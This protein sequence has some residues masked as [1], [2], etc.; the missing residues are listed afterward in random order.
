MGGSYGKFTYAKITEKLEKI[1]RHNKS[2]SSRKSYIGINTIVVQ[3]IHNTTAHEVREEMV[4]MRTKLMLVLKP[5]TGGAENVNALNYMTK[6]QQSE[7]L[8]L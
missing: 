1:S 4:Q 3:A 8:Y 2:W 7:N 5:V 6:P